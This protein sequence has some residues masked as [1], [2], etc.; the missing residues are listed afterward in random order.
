MSVAIDD[1]EL[2]LYGQVKR[3]L[4]YLLGLHGDQEDKSL[5]D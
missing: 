1:L 5:G 3:S 2:P 4:Y